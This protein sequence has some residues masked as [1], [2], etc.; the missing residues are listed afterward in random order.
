MPFPRTPEAKPANCRMTAR[1]QRISIIDSHTA[2]EP[3]RVVTDGA[4]DLGGGSVAEQLKVLQAKHDWLRTTAINEP[5]G[6]EVLVGAMLCPPADASCVAGVIYFNNVGYLG[7]CGHGTIGVVKTLAHLGRISPGSHRIET[8]V[9]IVTTTLHDDGSVSF[10]NVPSYRKAKG[11]ELQLEGVGR[12]RGDINWGGNWF[13]LVEDHRERI[14]FDNIE[15]LTAITWQIRRAINSQ[16]YPEVDHVDLFGVPTIKS[17]TRKTSYTAPAERT[18][19]RRVARA[20]AP[21][22]LR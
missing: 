17:T 13:Y 11:V 9:G 4:P 1:Q 20:R 5:R 8:T 12:I 7:M 15:H 2:G 14:D 18:I 22:W 16:G 19:V 6:S 3:T 10:T 21:S